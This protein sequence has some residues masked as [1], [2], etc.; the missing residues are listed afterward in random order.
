MHTLMISSVM[1]I[2][3][4]TKDIFCQK[5]TANLFI[6]HGL[7]NITLTSRKPISQL[8]HVL[9]KENQD[10]TNHYRLY[11]Q[12]KWDDEKLFEPILQSLSP[13]LE[14]LNFLSINYDETSIPKGGKKIPGVSL[15]EILILLNFELISSWPYV[16]DKLLSN[17]LLR[18]IIGSQEVFPLILRFV[19][20]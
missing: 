3:S 20:F 8:I 2:F 16:V 12:D 6:Q 18:M 10:W 5:R 1:D 11:S 15:L 14:K 13:D 4:K 7:A 9:G 19:L 17:F